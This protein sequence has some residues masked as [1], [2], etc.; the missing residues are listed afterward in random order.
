MKSAIFASILFVAT[1]IAAP[2][3]ARAAATVGFALSNDQS[4]SYAGVTFPAD[5]LDKTV[6]SLFGST[7]V[8]SSGHVL[9]SS[10]QLTQFPGTINCVLKNNGAV[11]ATFTAQKTFADLD[12][13]PAKATPINLDNAT[14]NCHA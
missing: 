5:G 3:E 8:G 13:N 4:G 6:S 1:A 9:A 14:I 7:S 10:A 11:L 12:G 2:L